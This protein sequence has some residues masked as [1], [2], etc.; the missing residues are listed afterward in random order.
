MSARWR[1]SYARREALSMQP[2]VIPGHHR[3]GRGVRWLDTSVVGASG[4]TPLRRGPYATHDLVTPTYWRVA[5]PTTR[6]AC[7]PNTRTSSGGGSRLSARWRVSYARREALSMQPGVI[8]GHGVRWLDTSVV[9]ASGRTP[10]RRGPYAT[11]DLVT[12]TYWRVAAPTT[13]NACAPN[14]RTSSGGGSR[15]PS[16]RSRVAPHSSSPLLTQRQP[17]VKGPTSPVGRH[18]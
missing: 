7:A 12:P 13:R 2:G 6:N 17:S 8:P 4:R 1:V 14:T 10:L 9:G 5:A 18:M 16:S 3:P 11:H 15:R